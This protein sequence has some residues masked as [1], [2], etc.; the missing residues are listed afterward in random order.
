MGKSNIVIIVAV[1]VILIIIIVSFKMIKQNKYSSEGALI[2]NELRVG[3]IVYPPLLTRDAKTG[4]LSGIS[5][6]LV[7]E[8]AAELG[9]TTNW[10]E[11]VGWGTA[12]EGLSTGRYDILGTQMWPNEAREKKAV[13]SIAPMDSVVYPYVKAGDDRY[14]SDLTKINSPE[15]R[16]VSLDGEMGVFITQEDYPNATLNTLPQLSSY[17]EIFLNIVQNKADLTF[18]EPSTAEDFLSSNPGTI[19]RVGNIPVRSFGNSFAFDKQNTELY[20]LWNKA[21]NN[22]MKGNMVQTT[23]EKYGAASHYSIN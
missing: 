5:Y 7:E 16:I 11:E 19:E 12:I 21:L 15:N 8:I 9:F 20:S 3:Y 22:V 2:N 6:D 14:S 4:E 18:A 23:L 13:F 10:V 1:I 17:A